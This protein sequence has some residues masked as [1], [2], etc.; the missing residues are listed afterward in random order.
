MFEVVYYEL[1]DG[2]EPVKDFIEA[3]PVKMRAKIAMELSVLQDLGNE[4][5]EPYSKHLEDG[6]FEMRCKVG[7]DITRLLYFFCG[8]KIV[9]L[10]NGFVKKGRKT[11][12]AE[13]KL[14][15]QRRADYLERRHNDDHAER[16][17]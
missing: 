13:I 14:A 5:R 9:V 10:T 16:T 17:S 7:A 1:S 6:I 3:Q 15:K 8:G 12:R 4:L 11:P 2:T